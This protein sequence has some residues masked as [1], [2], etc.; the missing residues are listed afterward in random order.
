MNLG[1][2]RGSQRKES[3]KSISRMPVR[4]GGRMGWDGIA[5]PRKMLSSTHMLGRN[6]GKANE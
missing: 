3:V 1:R 6:V 5:I 4:A 2:K